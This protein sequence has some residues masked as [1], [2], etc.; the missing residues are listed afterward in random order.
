MKISKY[1]RDFIQTDFLL[2]IRNAM[3][4]NGPLTVYYK[5]AEKLQSAGLKLITKEIESYY[6]DSLEVQSVSEVKVFACVMQPV[7]ERR[8]AKKILHCI[9]LEEMMFEALE[10]DGVIVN[11]TLILI[12]DYKQF[13]HSQPAPTDPDDSSFRNFM[14]L[15]C[16]ISSN[17]NSAKS[18]SCFRT[19]T[20]R[21]IEPT[22]KDD[23]ELIY[24]G[25]GSPLGYAYIKSLEKFSEGLH[26][27]IA[28]HISQ[29]I[30]HLTCGAHDIIREANKK[31]FKDSGNDLIL[32]TECGT[33]NVSQ[34]RH[35]KYNEELDTLCKIAEKNMYMKDGEDGSIIMKQL[36]SVTSSSIQFES[37]SDAK[38]FD[39]NAKDV[40]RIAKRWREGAAISSEDV[41]SLEIIR[42]RLLKLFS[43]GKGKG[44]VH[45]GNPLLPA[46][47]NQGSISHQLNAKNNFLEPVSYP[48]S[49]NMNAAPGA[50]FQP[51]FNSQRPQGTISLIN[52]SMV[53]MDCGAA[54]Q[55][56]CL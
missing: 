35:S 52:P 44:Q 27:V 43:R 55:V 40:T 10:P 39:D 33:V 6:N 11:S 14:K 2:I 56:K 32:N 5:A 54:I 13:H 28:K 9:D 53:C 19:S 49:N 46:P 15:K 20:Y 30:S 17:V 3:I 37:H 50:T 7:K 51:Q 48:L 29:K 22:T 47:S 24:L 41:L 25:Y 18:H 4:Y 21:D 31:D 16:L 38:L 45:L 42:N 1:L 36:A 8:S 12:L 23:K 26:P 34:E